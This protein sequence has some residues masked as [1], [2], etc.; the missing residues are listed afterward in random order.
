[1]KRG[2][3]NVP[4]RS[5]ET[6]TTRAAGDDGDFAFEGEDGGE[7]LQLNLFFSRHFGEE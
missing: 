7:A 1:L 3:K 6:Q 4:A 2:R 5:V